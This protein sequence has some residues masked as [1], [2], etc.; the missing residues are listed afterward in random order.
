M[1]SKR[2]GADLVL[3]SAQDPEPLVRWLIDTYGLQAVLQAVA[4]YQPP[5]VAAQSPAKR[6]S[7]KGG[8][9]GRPK[10]SKSGGGKRGRKSRKIAGGEGGGVVGNG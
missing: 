6:A 3:F 7:K 8:K 5:G 9:R 10:G 2:K 4:Q 1:P